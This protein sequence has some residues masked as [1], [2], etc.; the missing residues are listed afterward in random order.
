M[1]IREIRAFVAVADQ[2]SVSRAAEQIHLSQPAVS[3]RIASLEEQLGTRL[4]DRVGRNVLITE[5][6]QTFLPHARHILHSIDDGRKAID[7]LASSVGGRLLLGTSHHIGLHRL[8]PILRTYSQ[9][10]PGVNLQLHF[11][12]SEL[13]IEKILNGDLD[14][15]VVTLPSRNIEYLHCQTLWKDKLLFV[16]SREYTVKSTVTPDELIRMPSILPERGTVTRDILER[17][18]SQFDISLTQTLSTNYLETIKMMVSVGLGWSILP[19]TMI[20]PELQAF[21][22][23]N[24]ALNRNLGLVFDQRR[25]LPKAAKAL[26][27]IFED[28]A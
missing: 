10:Y 15:G 19:E 7:N 12:D 25:T 28:I 26:L 1:D 16:V 24:I 18:L 17:A 2:R 22:V 27:T 6:G 3:K 14:I 23:K 11:N 5:A 9:Q 4:F 13:V 8:P 21:R 20:T